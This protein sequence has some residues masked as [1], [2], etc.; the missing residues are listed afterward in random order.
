MGENQRRRLTEIDTEEVSMVDRAANKR[1]FSLIKRDQG[2]T[3]E[4]KMSENTN[5]KDPTVPGSGQTG[6]Q[7]KAGGGD[8]IASAIK[9]VIPVINETMAS[10]EAGDLKSAMAVVVDHLKGYKE[11]RKVEDEEKTEKAKDTEKEEAEKDDAEKDKEPAQ[12]VEPESSSAPGGKPNSGKDDEEE[13][14]EKKEKTQKRES[15]TAAILAELRKIDTKYQAKFEQL[16]NKRP[17]SKGSGD[18]P[19]SPT[20]VDIAKAADTD[21]FGDFF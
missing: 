3:Q 15:S 1:R 14:D 4:A 5:E 17:V 8:K 13:D 7:E 19:S 11:A 21:L 9:M 20:K 16:E 6:E 2:G 18:P 12:K 10:L